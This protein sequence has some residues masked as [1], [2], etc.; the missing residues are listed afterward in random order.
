MEKW[1]GVPIDVN[2]YLCDEDEFLENKSAVLIYFIRKNTY[3]G[4]FGRR[5]SRIFI[6]IRMMRIHEKEEKKM[7]NYFYIYKNAE[8]KRKG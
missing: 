1:F 6:I 2:S 5:I 7:K 3:V 8:K 4:S